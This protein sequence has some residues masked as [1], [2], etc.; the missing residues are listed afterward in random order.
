MTSDPGPAGVRARA[1]A[2]GVR[3]NCKKRA[4]AA[5]FTTSKGILIV[6]RGEI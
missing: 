2:A 1:G 5:A 3:W 4:H 6:V